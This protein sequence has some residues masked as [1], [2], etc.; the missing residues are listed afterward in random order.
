MSSATTTDTVTIQERSAQATRELWAALDLGAFNPAHTKYL[1]VALAQAAAEEA[2]KNANFAQ[3]V[4]TLHQE[5]VPA[6]ASR[7]ALVSDGPARSTAKGPQRVELIPISAVSEDDL[8]PYGPPNAFVLQRLYGNYQ[9]R[10]ALERYSLTALKDAFP[11]VQEHYPG[12]RPKK[13]TKPGIIDYIV[14]HVAGPGY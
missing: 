13:I 7:R 6:K 5:L 12:T 4:R 2:L 1:S 11:L 10:Q 3:R 14:E 8:N 9:L